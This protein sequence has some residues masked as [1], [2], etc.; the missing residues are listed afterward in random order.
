MD[1]VEVDGLTIAFE[2]RGVGPP[3]VLLHGGMSDHREWDAQLAG[4][5]DAFSVIAWDA[6]GCGDSSDPPSSFR[7]SDYGRVLAALLDRL[8]LGPSHVGGLSWGSTLALE[9]YRQRPELP[10]TLVLVAPYAGWAG[11]LPRQEIAAR[12]E[13]TLSHIERPAREWAD[14]LLPS[15]VADTASDQVRASLVEIMASSRPTGMRPM[16]LAMAEA[17][18]RPVLP[19]IAVPTLLLRGE[20]DRRSPAAAVEEIRGAIPGAVL[21]VLD[22]VGH[23]ANVESPE[24]FDEAVRSFLRGART[25]P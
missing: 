12:L 18:L 6:P 17:D 13:A 1:A 22:G 15:L 19:A 3:L 4:L 24:R 25:A 5:S 10:T 14:E 7:L 20:D 2:R 11:S 8:D 21:R 16:V 9:L 23:Q